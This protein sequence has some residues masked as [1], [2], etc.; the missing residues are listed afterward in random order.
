MPFSHRR[1]KLLRVAIERRLGVLVKN[2]PPA[3]IAEVSRGPGVRIISR[4]IVGGAFAQNDSYQVVRTG[5]VVAILHFG[6]DFVVGLGSHLRERNSIG[7]ITQRAEGF[8]VCHVREAKELYQVCGSAAC[9]KEVGEGKK[10]AGPGQTFAQFRNQIPS[11]NR[12]WLP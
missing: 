5:C 4:T 10:L 6:S 12:K 11:W 7:I 8:D 9:R 3:P 1:R 2:A